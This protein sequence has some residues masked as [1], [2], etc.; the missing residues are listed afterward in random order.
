MSPFVFWCNLLLRELSQENVHTSL[1]AWVSG[2]CCQDSS[3]ELRASFFSLSGCQIFWTW[4]I[5]D[6]NLT[7]FELTRIR[8]KLIDV[9]D[10]QNFSMKKNL[11]EDS[12]LLKTVT[13]IGNQVAE[14][15]VVVVFRCGTWKIIYRRPIYL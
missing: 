8:L 9:L 3:E 4:L 1:Y 10:E 14:R 5:D 2:D 11:L 6:E 15:N 13:R 12:N 7:R